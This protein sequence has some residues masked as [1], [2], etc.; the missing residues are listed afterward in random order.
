MNN[1]INAAISSI[2]FDELKKQGKSVKWLAEQ[3]DISVRTLEKQKSRGELSFKA[4]VRSCKI[5]NINMNM[6]K[7]INEQGQI[8]QYLSGTHV[9]LKDGYS[10]QGIIDNNIGETKNDNYY[11]IRTETGI[12][13][14]HDSEFDELEGDV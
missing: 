11:W 8:R 9:I 14:V 5:L 3:I 12:F 1:I 13:Q 10:T 4:W 7:E 6:F 2:I